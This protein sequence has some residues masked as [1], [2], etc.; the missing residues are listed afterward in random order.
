ML[1]EREQEQHE[2]NYKT[3]HLNKSSMDSEKQIVCMEKISQNNYFPNL[4]KFFVRI[5]SKMNSY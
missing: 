1:W 2:V 5:F 3:Q 4:N